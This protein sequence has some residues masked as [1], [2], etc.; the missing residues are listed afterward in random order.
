MPDTETV[1]AIVTDAP[2]AAVPAASAP[3]EPGAAS[4][5][6][7]KF[8]RLF[9]AEEAK[10]KASESRI[11]EY[12][13]KEKAVKDSELSELERE[14]AARVAAEE[15]AKGLELERL[16]EKVAKAANLPAEALEL[17]AGETEEALTAHAAKLAAI[18]RQPAQGGTQTAPGGNHQPTMDERIEAAQKAGNTLTAMALKRQQAFAPRSE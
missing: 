4:N 18:A 16:R 2:A 15:K 9:E 8:R 13:A 17:L 6:E 14:K 1:V 12:E 5:E 3:A 10:R 11:A 7:N